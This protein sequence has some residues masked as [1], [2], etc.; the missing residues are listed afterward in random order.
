MHVAAMKPAALSSEDISNE[1]LDKK[2]N[3]YGSSKRKW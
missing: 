2:R 1:D 3:I